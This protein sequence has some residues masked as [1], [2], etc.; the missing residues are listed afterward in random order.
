MADD[1]LVTKL[2]FPFHYSMLLRSIRIY[3]MDMSA[4][5]EMLLKGKS[6]KEAV[7]LQPLICHRKLCNCVA[8]FMFRESIFMSLVSAEGI[9]CMQFFCFIFQTALESSLHQQGKSEGFDS[10]DH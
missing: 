9:S 6:T 4:N 10:C 2:I 1:D 5:S 7:V 8:K 3:P